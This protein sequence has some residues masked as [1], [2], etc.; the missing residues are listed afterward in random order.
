MQAACCITFNG[1]LWW[2]LATA[3]KPISGLT[4]TVRNKCF[5]L[6][7]PEVGLKAVAKHHLY[8]PRL[9][10]DLEFPDKFSD[11]FRDLIAILLKT[12]YIL[13]SVR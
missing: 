2:C 11:E 12:K 13:L 4:Q 10:R 5:Q 3:F 9:L 7:S 8:I 6:I 1:K